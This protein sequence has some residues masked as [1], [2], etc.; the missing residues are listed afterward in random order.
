M[1]QPTWQPKSTLFPVSAL[2]PAM[3][4]TASN[5]RQAGGA[6]VILPNR[7]ACDNRWAA[8]QP[9]RVA[10]WPGILAT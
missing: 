10:P 5:L 3:G 7:G 1:I 6:G 9:C 8:H 2:V 4:L